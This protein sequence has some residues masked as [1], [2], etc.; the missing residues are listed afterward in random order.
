MDL[1]LTGDKLSEDELVNLLDPIFLTSKGIVNR[2]YSIVM[3]HPHY[4]GRRGA[5][6]ITAL[7]TPRERL[8]ARAKFHW[9]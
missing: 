2:G 6:T 4:S 3:L 7:S 9:A 1:W 5:F 8:R